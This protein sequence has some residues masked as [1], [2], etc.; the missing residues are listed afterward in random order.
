[1]RKETVS[2]LLTYISFLVLVIGFAFM[3]RENTRLTVVNHRLEAELG[4]VS[5]ELVESQNEAWGYKWQL[6]QI[7]NDYFGDDK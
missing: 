4:N 1:M 6:H 5:N 7:N 3:L 2:T